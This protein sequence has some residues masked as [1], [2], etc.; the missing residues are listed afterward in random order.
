MLK[1]VIKDSTLVLYCH[2]RCIDGVDINV[3]H[4]NQEKVHPR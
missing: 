4:K 3:T 1:E 2:L